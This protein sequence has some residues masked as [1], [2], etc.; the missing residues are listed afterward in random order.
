MYANNC[1]SIK[2]IDLMEAI[3]KIGDAWQESQ[4]HLPEQDDFIEEAACELHNG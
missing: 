3:Q 1:N 2:T 4:L